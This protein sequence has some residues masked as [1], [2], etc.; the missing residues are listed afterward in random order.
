MTG[1]QIDKKQGNQQSAA[2][3]SGQAASKERV[4]ARA[5]GAT[6]KKEPGDGDLDSVRMYLSKIG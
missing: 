2:E 4:G 5:Q 3:A 1:D 6:A